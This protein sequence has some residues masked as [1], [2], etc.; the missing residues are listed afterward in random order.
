MNSFAS[1]ATL[2]SGNRS[3]TIY[4]LPALTVRGFDLSRLPFSL[5]IRAHER[6][7][8]SDKVT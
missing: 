5:K 2:A 4:R 3:Y 6:L 8:A 1:R 7:Q